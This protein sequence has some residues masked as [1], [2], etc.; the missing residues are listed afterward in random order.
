MPC[1]ECK[2]NPAAVFLV[3]GHELCGECLERLYPERVPQIDQA[4][5]NKRVAEKMW[6]RMIDLPG[7]AEWS[8]QYKG[9]NGI[10]PSLHEHHLLVHPDEYCSS[11]AWMFE[12]EFQSWLDSYAERGGRRHDLG[13]YKTD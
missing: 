2:K 6:L 1:T 13:E 10:I 3:E 5:I 8:A 11:L 12:R 9:L 4:A 7:Y